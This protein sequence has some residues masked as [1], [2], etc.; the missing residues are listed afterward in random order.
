MGNNEV[1]DYLSIAADISRVQAAQVIGPDVVE[2][3]H[4]RA[5]ERAENRRRNIEFAQSVRE[6][7]GP[8]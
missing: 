6:M 7:A 2:A 4:L 1:M 8:Q 5:E 3:E